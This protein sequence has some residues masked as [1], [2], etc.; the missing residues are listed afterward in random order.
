MYIFFANVCSGGGGGRVTVGNVETRFC[1]RVLVAIGWPSSV[2]ST[3]CSCGGSSGGGIAGVAFVCSLDVML[4]FLF[5]K[6][7]LI[8]SSITFSGYWF[9]AR[10]TLN[11][12]NSSSLSSLSEHILQIR[13]QRVLIKLILYFLEVRLA[14]L[15]YMPV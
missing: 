13:S 7:L 5:L 1:S 8:A 2:D 3:S 15:R 11:F 10:V 4:W 9:I 6:N 14:Q 12:R